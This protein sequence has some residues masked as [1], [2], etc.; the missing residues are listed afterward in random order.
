M[1]LLTVM[2]IESENIDFVF[3][4]SCVSQNYRAY[5][6]DLYNKRLLYYQKYMYLLVWSYMRA[7]ISD[8]RLHIRNAVF[9][10]YAIL[11]VLT[12]ITPK[13]QSYMDVVYTYQTTALL[14]E[15]SIFWV[16]AA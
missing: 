2:K 12:H 3:F 1:N 13:L 7:T 9:F 16:R 15:L 10:Q 5:T 14:S 6:N 11:C 4:P 8:S